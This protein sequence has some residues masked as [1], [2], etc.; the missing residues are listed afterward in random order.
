MLGG[1]LLLAPA[2]VAAR[3]VATML[4]LVLVRL[5]QQTAGARALRT[6]ALVIGHVDK[7]SHKWSSDDRQRYALNRSW[8]KPNGVPSESLQTVQRSPG[9][10]T[11]PPSAWTCFSASATSLTVK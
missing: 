2:P 8:A 9:W 6:L 7:S 4:G 5:A 1:Y 3:A 11:L 10:T